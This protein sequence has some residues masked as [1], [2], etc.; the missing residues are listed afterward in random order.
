MIGAIDGCI[1]LRHSMIFVGSNNGEKFLMFIQELV[2]K[3]KGTPSILVLDNL[4][5]HKVKKVKDFIQDS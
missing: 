3:L 4:S 5:I 1:G 2:N